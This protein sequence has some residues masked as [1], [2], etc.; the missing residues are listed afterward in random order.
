[1]FADSADS[2]VKVI[3]NLTFEAKS[4]WTGF[5][6][7]AA[8]PSEMLFVGISLVDSVEVVTLGVKSEC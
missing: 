1:V 6:V 2:G 5:R 4:A 8:E 3:A 7:H